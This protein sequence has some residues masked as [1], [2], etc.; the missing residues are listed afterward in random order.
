[1]QGKWGAILVLMGVFAS[2][3]TGCGGGGDSSEASITKKEFVVQAN[4][5]C[6]KAEQA[7]REA[8]SAYAQEQ[9]KELQE[10]SKPELETMI[11]DAALPPMSAMADELDALPD[12]EGEDASAEAIV[13]DFEKAVEKTEEQPLSVL[14]TSTGPFA[15]PLK[16]SK[17]FGL[18]DCA[19]VS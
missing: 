17:S 11:I 4:A 6:R 2:M 3:A 16:A 1:V 13:T 19:K 8:V 9:G 12:P 10:F 7:R 15:K 18:S 14:S 5:I